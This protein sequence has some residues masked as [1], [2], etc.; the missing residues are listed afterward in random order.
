[1]ADKKDNKPPE[2]DSPFNSSGE[3]FETLFREE[4][5]TLTNGQKGK[6]AVPKKDRRVSATK[7]PKPPAK[8]K[9][10]KQRKADPQA[11]ARAKKDV[12]QKPAARVHV[13]RPERVSTKPAAKTSTVVGERPVSAD[14]GDGPEEVKPEKKEK[15][16]KLRRGRIGSQPKLGG[17]SDKIKIAG[18]C[19]I[20]VVAVAFIVNTLGI[21]DFGGL[22]GL[23]EP[24]KKERIKPRVA[25]KPPAKADKKTTRVAIKPSQRKTSNQTAKK[26]PI[27]KKTLTVRKSPQAVP[28]KPQPRTV[29]KTTPP[30][31][32]A[33]K[34]VIA[35]QRYRLATP[36]KRPPAVQQPPKPPP[37]DSRPVVVMKPSQPAPT[38]QK[39]VV[40]KKPYKPAPPQPSP[41]VTKRPPPVVRPKPLPVVKEPARPAAQSG[42]RPALGKEELFPEESA[43]PYPY[44]VYLGAYKTTGRAEK[45]IS[46]YRNKGLSAYWVKVD[47][48]DKGVWYRVFTGYF[49]DQNEAEAFIRRKQIADAKAK[50]TR[51]AT[52]IGIYATERDAQKEFLALSRL[53]FSPYV[54]ET[55]SGE[56]QLYVGAFYTKTGAEEQRSDLASKGVQSRV[57]ER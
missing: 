36:A 46:I 33:K 32:T 43:L 35:Q 2:D 37:P 18:L 15:F 30:T 1:M 12:E 44:S 10:P 48:G 8:E 25:R 42:K 6:K 3:L 19:V 49:K 51:Y 4:L 17:G 50:R 39:P 23:S 41:V 21:V 31:P 54:I 53:G 56:S 14:M 7:R 22:L 38:T 11:A 45:A 27:Q 28:P 57:V 55:D 5:D 34:P 24:T 47:L 52:L 20:L 29:Q 40:N 9:R 26:P 13:D 16:W